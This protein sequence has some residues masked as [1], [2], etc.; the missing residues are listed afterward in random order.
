MRVHV[1]GIARATVRVLVDAGCWIL[2]AD[3]NIFLLTR[4]TAAD[5]QRILNELVNAHTLVPAFLS[6]D[7]LSWFRCESRAN[8]NVLSM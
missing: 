5:E 8:F 6:R 3:W 4:C 2:D 7:V 1:N